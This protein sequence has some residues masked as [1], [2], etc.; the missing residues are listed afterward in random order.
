MTLGKTVAALG[1]STDVVAEGVA[2][3]RF[4]GII[5]AGE[6]DAIFCEESTLA[7]VAALR[8][9]AATAAGLTVTVAG[10]D[11]TVVGRE[12]A[13]GADKT[14]AVRGADK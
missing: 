2:L 8:D 4:A 5:T 6:R 10:L 11:R 7:L 3:C 9:E 1:G 12:L 13:M 14:A